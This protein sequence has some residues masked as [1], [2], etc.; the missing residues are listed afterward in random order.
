MTPA[1]RIGAAIDVIDRIQDGELADR[2]LAHWGRKNRYA[3]SK[4]RAAIADIV[5]AVLRK[6]QSLAVLGAGKTG[7]ALLIGYLRDIGQD[8]DA[9]F[10]ADRYAPAALTEAERAAPEPGPENADFP[11]WLWPDLVRSQGDQALPIARAM[12]ERAP[13]YVRANLMKASREEAI[14][15]LAAEGV[16]GTAHALSPSA[17][18]ISE[19]ARKIRNA[20]PYLNGMIELQD[21]ASQAVADLVPLTL[22]E[23]FLDFCAGGGGKVLAVAGRIAGEFYA[24][25]A[26]LRRM[27]D[28]PARAARAGTQVNLVPPEDLDALPACHTV[29]VDAPCS[30]SGSWRR[31]PH[32]KWLL[33]RDRLDQLVEMQQNILSRASGLVRPGGHLV[34]ATC[35]LLDV[36]NDQQS[37]AFLARHPDFSQVGA[38][39]FTPLSGGDGFFCAVFAKD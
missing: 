35:S 25:D 19:G 18:H 9:V 29:L 21:A 27:N 12:R 22:G 3:G 16:I 6:K 20:Q 14:A 1:A 7:R 39:H 13:I 37:A 38:H 2:S 15:A 34:Y 26:D 30:G 31:D 33:T 23:R 28:L 5:Y 8:P 36:E 17:V 24:H 4:D 11:E 32:G 10:G